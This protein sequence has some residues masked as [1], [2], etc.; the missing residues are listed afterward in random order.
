MQFTKHILLS[1]C[2]T[3]MMLSGTLMSRAEG[4]YAEAEEALR[5]GEF[6]L[7]FELLL[8]HAKSGH[9]HAQ[10]LLGLAYLQGRGVQ[11]SYP[12]AIIW[13]ERSANNGNAQSQN[14]LGVMYAQGL[15]V[16]Q[17]FE[18]AFQWFSL[19]AE[20]GDDNAQ[21]TLGHMYR[22]GDGVA[23]SPQDALIWF[24]RSAAQGNQNAMR[25]RDDLSWKLAP[26]V[27]DVNDATE[28]IISNN[29]KDHHLVN[30]LTP[31]GK[32]RTDSVKV[33]IVKNLPPENL[34]YLSSQG[35]NIEEGMSYLLPNHIAY[36]LS[37]IA[38]M[39]PIR[40]VDRSLTNKQI[41][42]EFG[43]ILN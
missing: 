7:A 1:L 22:L 26:V 37:A 5:R 41:A 25:E 21:I 3:S 9:A 40:S 30:Y 16:Q 31:S 24:E 33:L 10:S 19:A 8:P 42:A 13:F 4:T 2:L 15:G 32:T 14:N 20:Q 38:V 39:K 35:I 11:R 36:S 23:Q 29:G 43:L 12:D 27:T 17:S 18:R 6:A 34:E 28:V